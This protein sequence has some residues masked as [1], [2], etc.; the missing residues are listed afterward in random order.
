MRLK[1]SSLRAVLAAIWLIAMASGPNAGAAELARTLAPHAA[2]QVAHAA[3]AMLLAS[4]LAGQRMVAVGDHGVVLLSDDNGS[5]FRQAR[6][7]P[8]DATLTGVSFIDGKQGWAVGQWGAI[9]HSADGGETWAFQR[10]DTSVD[11][12]LFA[13]HFFDANKG[14]AV[15]LWSLVLATSDGF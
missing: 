12:P 10:I 1:I 13:V 3:T 4:T 5:H 15:G 7:V 8:F 14:V 11:R 6:T 9:L 2:P